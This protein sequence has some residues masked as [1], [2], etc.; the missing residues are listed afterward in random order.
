MKLYFSCMKL[1][2]TGKQNVIHLEIVECFITIY[3]FFMRWITL[4]SF[5]RL[6]LVIVVHQSNINPHMKTFEVLPWWKGINENRV[7]PINLVSNLVSNLKYLLPSEDLN[8]KLSFDSNFILRTK[9]NFFYEKHTWHYRNF[10]QCE[11][12]GKSKYFYQIML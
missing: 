2:N 7:R 5:S 10:M 6:V 8:I 1:N 11:F 9:V 12:L 4:L 3:R